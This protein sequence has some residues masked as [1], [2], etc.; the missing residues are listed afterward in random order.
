[1]AIND[2]GIINETIQRKKQVMN[3][4]GVPLMIVA[5]ALEQI[6]MCDFIVIVVSLLN[7]EDHY[8]TTSCMTFVP[9]SG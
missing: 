1:L 6:E 8:I 4:L 9:C 5:I 3:E 7:A 2:G